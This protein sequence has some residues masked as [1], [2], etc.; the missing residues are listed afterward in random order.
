M[1]FHLSVLAFLERYKNRIGELQHTFLT[2]A[3]AALGL[4][5]YLLPLP[6]LQRPGVAAAAVAGGGGGEGGSGVGATAG[7]GADNAID[8]EHVNDDDADDDDDDALVG[9]PL[10]RPPPGWDDLAGGAQG[11]WAWG[12]EPLSA[13]ERS[14]AKRRRP[15]TLA[16]LRLALL[17]ASSWIAV[18][19][20]VL[21]CTAGPLA[22]GRLLLASL[23]LPPAA[24]HDPLAF[25][26]GVALGIL[27]KPPAA[28]VWRYFHAAGPAAG[29]GRGAP[30]TAHRWR[31]PP[32]RAVVLPLLGFGVAWLVVLPLALGAL[33]EAA[34]VLRGPVWRGIGGDGGGGDGVGA[35]TGD[36]AGGYGG[37][38]L[39]LGQ[40]WLLGLV[41]LHLWAC[42]TAS[43]HLHN[44]AA[45][46]PDAPPPGAGVNAAADG[47]G[48]DAGGADND[49]GDAGDGSVTW[50]ERLGA[51]G[52][53]LLACAEGHWTVTPPLAA[54][55]AATG[56][57]QQQQQ[58]APEV[59]LDVGGPLLRALSLPLAEAIASA[60]WAPLLAAAAA[61]GA[62]A[63][64]A[65]HS[66]REA[67]FQGSPL[68]PTVEASM[69]AVAWN[70]AA[71][72]GSAPGPG[73]LLLPALNAATCQAFA[74]V[75]SDVTSG[76]AASSSGA[77]TALG[78]FR[79]ALACGVLRKLGNRVARPLTEKVGPLY[80][81]ACTF[82]S[83]L[84]FGKGGFL[85][86]TERCS[87]ATDQRGA[88][89]S[90]WCT[91][92]SET[93]SISWP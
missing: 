82:V 11:R 38:A 72:A 47:G 21:A 24:L 50:G 7:P 57:A 52:G 33:L 29:A 70:A 27:L 91:T 92:A 1:M 77:L 8:D 84:F 46:A 3:C 67:L 32:L 54:T 25:G 19:A 41:L 34:F 39:A 89:R 17:F 9:P 80:F 43:G 79:C 62:A 6:K 76:F 90:S 36:A 60:A 78:A 69:V 14:I 85:V 64:L 56:V 63:A 48:A 66:V 81:L 61:S 35:G 12:A 26:A 23:R 22:A 73:L 86:S 5:R 15:A 18:L 87:P 65:R 40:D 58:L 31:A 4:T 30:G 71:A 44:R 2:R 10:Q 37:E 16:P 55:A 45:R 93:K 13:L 42:L 68:P 28:R 59:P 88:C 74:S 53:V 51:A 75:T 49:A 83:P 20:A